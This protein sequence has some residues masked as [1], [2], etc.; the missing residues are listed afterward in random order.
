[1]V[2]GAGDVRVRGGYVVITG[3]SGFLGTA[4]AARLTARGIPVAIL[5]VFPPQG[6]AYPFVRCDMAQGIPESEF[7]MYPRA[8]INLAGVPIFGRFTKE[9]K[10][11]IYDSR[12]L[13]TQKLVATFQDPARKPA[14]FVSASAVGYYGDAGNAVLTS[15][16]ARGVGFLADVAAAWEAAAGGADTYGVPT[17]II[18]NGHILGKGG[19]LGALAP[20]FRWGL[21]GPIGGGRHWMPWIHLDDCAEL[22]VR[23]ALGELSGDVL[24]AAAP[25]VVTNKTFSAHLAEALHRPMF[26]RIPVFLLWIR[27]GGLAHELV[28]SQRVT[29]ALGGYE[30][31][32]PELSGALA[33]I[34]EN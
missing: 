9:R 31:Q 15:V 11:A 24:V 26:L 32:F 25:D 4:I 17:T 19:L 13:G 18:R 10:R 21:G 8:I 1:M 29:P 22:Y 27:Y 34:F 20:V 12:V 3:G 30:L 6:A 14:Q 16:S 28:T 2:S 5:D 7:L 23:A 33:D